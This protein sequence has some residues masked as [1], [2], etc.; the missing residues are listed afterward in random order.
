MGNVARRYA[1]ALIKQ[2]A[3]D[4]N[5]ANA[6]LA[7]LKVLAELFSVP[8]GKKV[9][10]NPVMPRDLKMNL[11]NY[12]LTQGNAS[13]ELKALIEIMAEAG[14]IGQIP[15]VLVEYQNFLN[16]IQGTVV[17]EL[18]TA[19]ALS[20]AEKDSFTKELSAL[21]KK[22]VEIEARVDTSILG[23]FVAK[24]GNYRIDLSLKSKL[25][26]ISQDAVQDTL[27]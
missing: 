20:A 8:A 10:Q 26:G 1:S 12:G 6:N 9:L 25:E 5:K 11:L 22:K 13:Q 24:I 7:S 2:N 19:V 23:G 27:G 18:V 16:E 15:L 3:G 17:A 14:R 21:V 4:P